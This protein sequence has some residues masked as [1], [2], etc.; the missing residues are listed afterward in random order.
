MPASLAY[1][2]MERLRRLSLAD[3]EL[4][5]TQVWILRYRLL[6]VG[7]VIVLH[8]RRLRAYLAS[9]FPYQAAFWPAA[10]RFATG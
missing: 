7:A 2:L 8:T 1:V 3:T 5:R 4:A 6:E 9:V 10:E